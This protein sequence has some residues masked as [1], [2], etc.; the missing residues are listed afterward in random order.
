VDWIGDILKAFQ[1]ADAGPSIT[2][3]WNNLDRVRC[4][5]SILDRNLAYHTF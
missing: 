2:V 4:E 5:L 1:Q 3:T